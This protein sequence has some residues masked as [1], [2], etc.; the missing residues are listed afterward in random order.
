MR[1]KR[2]NR[3]IKK[4]AKNLGHWSFFMKANA[5]KHYHIK[6]NFYDEMFSRQSLS[7]PFCKDFVEDFNDL[8]PADIKRAD[9]LS[10]QFFLQEGITFN[11]YG[12][13]R[14]QDGKAFPVDIIPRILSAKDWDFLDRGLNQ[15]LTALNLFLKDIYTEEKILKDKVIPK[16]IVY[17]SPY[18]LREMKNTKVPFDVYVNLCGTD[19]VRTKDGFF[20]LEDNLRV[21]SGSSYMLM[22]RQIMRQNFIRLF[23][24]C[25]VK[26]IHSYPLMLLESLKS[27]SKKD[28]PLV[29][30]LTPGVFNSAYFEHSF[31]ADQMGVPLVQ[32]QDLI[33]TGE[34]I[35]MKTIKGLKK[36]DVIYRRI[37]D[38]FLDPLVFNSESVLGTPGLFSAYKTG[39]VVIANAPGTGI[40]DDKAIYSFVPQIIKYYLNEDP[41]LKNVPTLLCRN[42]K[43][44]DHII[45]NIKDHVVKPVDGSGGY[46]LLMGS[47]ASKQE[48]N[49]YIEKL[50]ANPK[51][52]IAQSILHLS[53]APCFINNKIEPRHV[54]LRPFVLFDKTFKSRIIPGALCRVALKK[55]SLV[56]NSSQG[57]GC[58]DLWVLE[59]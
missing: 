22:C 6:E 37:D 34:E 2:L 48:Q 28:N 24:K 55:E 26:R 1:D 41:I 13:K 33:F 12:D 50:K 35:C 11:V 9:R 59:N 3:L 47:H 39:S 38:V 14:F 56:V 15:R 25:K 18:F 57:G 32:G 16:D 8:S 21:P 17:E 7:H 20:V 52:Y 43:Y 58:K 40:A 44:L 30:V 54:D 29:V 19:I 10:S 4:R 46:D 51:K 5:F 23:R 31:L 53:T 42:P 45:K 27:L 36:I 49:A